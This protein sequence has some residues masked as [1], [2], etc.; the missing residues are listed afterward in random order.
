MTRLLEVED[1]QFVNTMIPESIGLKKS[2]GTIR[3]GT[4]IGLVVLFRFSENGDPE[5]CF[6]ETA[7]PGEAGIGDDEFVE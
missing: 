5:P 6:Q 3:D 4:S 2:Q 1:I 7:R